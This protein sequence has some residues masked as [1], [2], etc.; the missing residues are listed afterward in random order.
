MG[1]P[2]RI[3]LVIILA[4][5]VVALSPS[6][7]TA[8]EFHSIEFVEEGEET[9]VE[10]WTPRYL[11]GY[12]LIG[13]GLTGYIVGDQMSAREEARI[14]PS[15]DPEHPTR[16][17]EYDDIDKP[18]QDSDTI[19]VAW[20]HGYMLGAAFAIAGLE[21]GQWRRGR[22]SGQ[23]FHDALIGFTEAS[24]LTAAL[25]SL[26]KPRFG[27][28]RPDFA[29]RA[30]RYH[31]TQTE[32]S[33][34]SDCDEFRDQPL[35]ASDRRSRRRLNDGKKSFFSGHAS[36]SFA[37]STYTTLLIG[38]NHV[39]GD[40]ASTRSRIV[41]GSAQFLL[42]GSAAFISA[43]RVTDGRHHFSDVATGAAVGTA[44]AKFSYWR[45]FDR[46]GNLRFRDRDWPHVVIRPST[47]Y[48]GPV[49]A[50]SW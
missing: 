40:D 20:V 10:W 29:E 45:R 35:H 2:Y 46:S 49:L 43:T 11:V 37:I 41:G 33:Y 36:N 22:G 38:G 48:T 9:L 27:R 3:L 44:I 19:P 25:T 50:V 31:C 8:E 39:W 1:T 15:Y 12:G 30:L 4:L 14:G 16:L 17:T 18:F 47:E 26:V 34:G 23:R 7:A 24:A 13:L 21:A 28:L 32:A 42:M 5:A 6:V